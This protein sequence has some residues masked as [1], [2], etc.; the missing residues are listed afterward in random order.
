M[1]LEEAKTRVLELIDLEYNESGVKV[2]AA[3][4]AQQ[5]ARLATIL[6]IAQKEI[7]QV[8]YIRRSVRIVQNNPENLIK[9]V[10]GIVTHSTEDIVYSVPA[11]RSY[12][13]SVDD[14]AAVT[15]RVV[16]PDG[17]TD[18]TTSH[19][20]IT[21]AIK[22]YKQA[23][24]LPDDA[25]EV[26]LIFA[27]NSRYNIIG[28]ALFAEAFSSSDR[29]PEWGEFTRYTMPTD[30]WMLDSVKCTLVD[31]SQNTPFIWEN[32]HTL[33]I[34]YDAAGEYVIAYYAWPKTILRNTPAEHEFE[35]DDDAQQVMLQFA[36][37]VLLMN[38]EGT[39]AIADRFRREYLQRIANL[40]PEKTRPMIRFEGGYYGL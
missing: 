31:N 5:T 17:N 9:G 14:A 36:A 12:S 38:D 21:G 29:I 18:V 19:T 40:I 39:I 20:D 11:A 8:K 25:T 13:F 15:I 22:T 37:Q 1:T 2:E 6:D 35:V 3:E 27:G 33:A 32:P 4:V 24:T 30:F 16:T 28:P 7:A 10:E 34:K 26:Q 23:I